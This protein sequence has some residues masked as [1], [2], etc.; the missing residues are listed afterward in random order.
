MP[1]CHPVRHHIWRECLENQA[2]S[3]RYPTFH[4]C[5][6]K[7]TLLVMATVLAF[8]SPALARGGAGAGGGHEARVQNAQDMM[9][10]RQEKREQ[11][12]EIRQE[13]REQAQEARKDRREEMKA[14]REQKREE[15]KKRIE[16]KKG[17]ASATGATEPVT[18][19]TVE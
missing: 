18:T 17:E 8:T 6:M 10:L 5:L 19:T 13:K 1:Q 14:V 3:R 15:I 7:K 2:T 4:R 9:E 12:K 11:A 16:E